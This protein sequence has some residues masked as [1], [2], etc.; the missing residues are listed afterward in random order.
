MFEHQGYEPRRAK[1]KGTT[2]GD[3]EKIKNK[4]QGLR[5]EPDRHRAG[6]P[7]L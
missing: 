2:G 1:F 4:S 6:M 3:V 7:I 5:F